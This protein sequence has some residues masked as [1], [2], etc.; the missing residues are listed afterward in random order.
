MNG[1]GERYSTPPGFTSVSPVGAHTG[2]CLASTS[3]L[4]YNSDYDSPPAGLVATEAKV[5]CAKYITSMCGGSYTF[6]AHIYGK[7]GAQWRTTTKKTR[8]KHYI[9]FYIKKNKRYHRIINLVSPS[10]RPVHLHSNPHPTAH[11]I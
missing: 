8:S 7:A 9:G 2:F 5:L 4:E 3:V 11:P 10:P 1:G 6:I